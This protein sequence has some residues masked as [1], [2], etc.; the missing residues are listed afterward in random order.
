MFKKPTMI[1]ITDNAIDVG[2]LAA[3]AAASRGVVSLIETKFPQYAKFAKGA[4]AVGGLVLASSTSNSFVKGAG[5]GMAVMQGLNLVTDVVAGTSMGQEL[6]LSTD[7]I[8]NAAAKTLGLACACDAQ[9]VFDGG[10][11]M[12]SRLAQLNS[13]VLIP[14]IVPMSNSNPFGV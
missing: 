13:A 3:G 1:A 7:P 11:P 9:P 12:Q 4:V 6:A 8:K 14:P 2:G 5:Q 10:F